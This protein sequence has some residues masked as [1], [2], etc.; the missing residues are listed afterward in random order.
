MRGWWGSESL[1]VRDGGWGGKV[2][3]LHKVCVTS[4]VSQDSISLMCDPQL[5]HAIQRRRTV[6]TLVF[7]QPASPF[8]YESDSML[9]FQKKTLTF[10]GAIA[11]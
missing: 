8:G 4:V 7:I 11:G 6:H 5:F 10:S 2:C 1:F 9:L 3:E